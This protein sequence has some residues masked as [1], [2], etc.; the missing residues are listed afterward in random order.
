MSPGNVVGIHRQHIGNQDLVRLATTLSGRG[1]R[2]GEIVG[3]VQKV[4]RTAADAKKPIPSIQFMRTV[5]EFCF[6][7]FHLVRFSPEARH[8]T[9]P[10]GIKK[11]KTCD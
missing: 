1:V 5:P 10:S 11:Q 2:C 6:S 7:P 9:F 3:E 4:A 8:H